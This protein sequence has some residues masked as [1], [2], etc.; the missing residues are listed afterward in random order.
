MYFTD[1]MLLWEAILDPNLSKYSIIILDEIHE[2]TIN[3]DVLLAL[4]KSLMKVWLDLKVILMSATVDIPK[5]ISYI[6]S[7]VV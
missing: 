3:T 6:D 5:M 7:K 1:G 2:R 4:V